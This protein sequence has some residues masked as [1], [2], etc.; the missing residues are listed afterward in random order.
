MYF[1]FFSGYTVEKGTVVFLNNYELNIGE[2]YW[3]NPQLFQ[4]ERFLSK[5]GNVTKPEYFIPFSTGKRMCIGQR[6][7]QG[8]SFILLASIIQHFDVSADQNTEIRTYPACVA[9]PPDTFPLIFI[10][11]SCS[12]TAV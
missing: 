5:E 1:L 9:V 3:S 10:P 8:F 11:R 4:P 6:L 7:V 2:Q 12:R